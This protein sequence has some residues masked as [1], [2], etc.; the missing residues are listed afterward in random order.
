MPE[1]RNME[2]RRNRIIRV[3][4]YVAAICIIGVTTTHYWRP[5]IFG[6]GSSTKYSIY[7]AVL[8][9]EHPEYDTSIELRWEV[10]QSPPSGSAVDTA[11]FEATIVFNPALPKTIHRDYYIAVAGVL[12]DPAVASSGCDASHFESDV[13][14]TPDDKTPGSSGFA[15]FRSAYINEPARVYHVGVDIASP[16]PDFPPP[17][18]RFVTLQCVFPLV[19][20]WTNDS[21][22]YYLDLP[23]LAIVAPLKDNVYRLASRNYCAGAMYTRSP[24]QAVLSVVPTATEDRIDQLTWKQCGD[25]SSPYNYLGY[26]VSHGDEPAQ[27]LR[28]PGVRLST[29]DLKEASRQVRVLFLAGVIAGFLAAIAIEILGI[30]IESAA[31]ASPGL[32]ARLRRT[33]RRIRRRFKRSKHPKQLKLW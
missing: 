21:P 32:P 14:A 5:F 6:G 7:S 27:V 33:T 2:E 30:V 1:P 19:S 15:E 22:D 17:G 29:H 10:E 13:Y 9:S 24:D 16:R 4:L 8:L 31:E 12:P 26:S 3:G 25:D 20:L 11:V 23:P 28:G 18:E